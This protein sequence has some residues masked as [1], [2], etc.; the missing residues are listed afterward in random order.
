M[1]SVQNTLT[2]IGNAQINQ[3]GKVSWSAT[4]G[5]KSI[6]TDLANLI[7]ER[8]AIL[9]PC[10]VDGSPNFAQLSAITPSETTICIVQ[11]AGIYVWNYTTSSWKDWIGTL[12]DATFVIG[13]GALSNVLNHKMATLTPT[14]VVYSLTPI[15]GTPYSFVQPSSY[16]YIVT[17]NNN[18]TLS[19]P[20]ATTS[21]W[22]VVV[23]R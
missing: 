14:V 20:S 22:L 18:I 1:T 17:D 21:D 16:T 15:T 13:S 12:D 9:I 5:E 6:L 11:N 3:E 19:S 23:K 7:K 4:N 8:G 2:N 10:N